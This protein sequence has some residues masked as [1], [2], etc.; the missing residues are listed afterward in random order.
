MIIYRHISFFVV[1]ALVSMITVSCAENKVAPPPPNSKA[2][3]L[4][5]H[6]IPDYSI[7]SDLR[8]DS[9]GR[10]IK[11]QAEI[12]NI[13][14]EIDEVFYRFRWYNKSGME[15]GAEESWKKL[16]VLDGAS[17]VV[18]GVAPTTDVADFRIELQSPFNSR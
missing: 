17:Q 4:I 9:S 13:S 12:S 2:A 10:F 1:L 18:T 6:G 5:L 3:K 15:T 8:M 14:G 16:V 11:V 7:L